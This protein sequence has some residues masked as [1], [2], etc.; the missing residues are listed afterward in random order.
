[1]AFGTDPQ[2]FFYVSTL[3]QT[4]LKQSILARV[5]QKRVVDALDR[6]VLATPRCLGE[7][8]QQGRYVFLRYGRFGYFV[9]SQEWTGYHWIYTYRT[10]SLDLEGIHPAEI[11]LDLAIRLLDRQDAIRLRKTVNQSQRHRNIWLS[12]NAKLN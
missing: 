1:M 4:L 7:D 10:A 11:T 9:A 8:Y 12:F 2:S 6:A 5:L 3:P